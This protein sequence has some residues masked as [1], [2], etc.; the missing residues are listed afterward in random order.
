MLQYQFS[1]AL[2]NMPLVL[3]GLGMALL[4]N[5]QQACDQHH[6]HELHPTVDIHAS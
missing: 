5:Q 4:L 3:V 1:Q 6:K 2:P